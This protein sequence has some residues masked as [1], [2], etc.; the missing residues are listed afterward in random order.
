MPCPP[1]TQASLGIG[2]DYRGLARVELRVGPMGLPRKEGFVFFVFRNYFS[3]RKQFQEILENVL[4][5]RKILRKLQ[6]FQQ[7]F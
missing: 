7:K 1:W 5:H 4:K 6:K 2:P 3:M